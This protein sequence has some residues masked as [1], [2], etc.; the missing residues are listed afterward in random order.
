[1]INDTK[2]SDSKVIETLFKAGAHFG[3]IRSRR[4]PS[5]RP[6][7]FGA[8]NKIEIFD[9]EKTEEALE[10]AKSFVTKEMSSGGLIIFVGGKSEARGAV[11]DGAVK[12]GMPYV[13]GRWLGGTLTNFSEIKKRL[14]R[15][16]DLTSQREKGELGKYTKKERLLIDREIVSLEESFSGLSGMKMLP[17]VM[18]VIDSKREKNAVAEAKKLHIPVVAVAS[19]DCDLNDVDYAIPANDA[20][21]ASVAFFVNEISGAVEA[22]QKEFAKGSSKDVAEP[23][24]PAVA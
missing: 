18:F 24:T 5:A 20:S 12:V 21:M 15:L 2:K 4:H 7:I 10:K 23:E 9:L 13:A 6:F 17:K 16:E 1:M 11:R 22:A 8:K 3:L 14:G 19:S